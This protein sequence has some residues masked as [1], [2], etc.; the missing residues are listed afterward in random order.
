MDKVAHKLYNLCCGGYGVYMIA[1]FRGFLRI[2][3]YK[4]RNKYSRS[5][6]LSL[7]SDWEAVGKDINSAIKKKYKIK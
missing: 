2:V 7:K 5:I 1:F 4:E 3:G 6:G